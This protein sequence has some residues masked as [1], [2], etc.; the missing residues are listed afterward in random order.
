M[1]SLAQQKKK[2][3]S[4]NAELKRQLEASEQARLDAEARAEN[5]E[6][7]EPPAAVTIQQD[8]TAVQTG[9]HEQTPQEPELLYDPFDSKNP[10]K[11]I[12]NPPGYR[13]GWK[14]PMYREKHRGWRG[15]ITVSYDDEIGRNLSKYLLDPPRKMSHVDDNLVRRGDVILCKLPEKMWL[16]RQQRRVDRA[17]R[18]RQ[19]HAPD[20]QADRATID[21]V[22]SGG[23]VQVHAPGSV[24]GSTMPSS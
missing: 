4:D 6:A 23:P 21:D 3:E 14:N 18:N 7:A 12:D 5:A 19:A 17:A 2:L 13:L 24:G 10:H 15:W 8:G 16:A 9:V 22:R 20:I 11:I 1:P